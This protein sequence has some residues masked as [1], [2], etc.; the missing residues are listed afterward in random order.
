MAWEFQPT[1]SSRRRAA[2]LAKFA[3]VLGAAAA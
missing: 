2:A 3:D 1:R